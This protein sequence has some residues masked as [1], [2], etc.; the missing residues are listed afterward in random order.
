MKIKL[1]IVDAFEAPW[2]P[3]PLRYFWEGE[4]MDHWQYSTPQSGRVVETVFTEG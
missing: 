2:S 3:A 4:H 1:I